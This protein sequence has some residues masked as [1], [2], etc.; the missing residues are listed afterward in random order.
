MNRVH[1]MQLRQAPPAETARA[2]IDLVDALTRD[3]E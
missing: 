1:Q 3:L 2:F